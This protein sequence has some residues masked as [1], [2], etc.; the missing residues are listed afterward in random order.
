[1]TLGEK[2]KKVR[3]TFGLS[4]E[5]LGGMLNVSRQAITKWETDSGMPDITNLQQLSSL[6]ELT[7]DYFLNNDLNLPLLVIRKEL[8]KDKYENKLK[9]YDKILAE[10]FK[11]PWNVYTLIKSEKENKLETVFDILTGGVVY[12]SIKEL[13]DLSVYCLAIKDDVKLLV[14]IKNWVLTIKELP[15]NI[16]E[17]KFTIDNKSFRKG[18][19]IKL[20]NIN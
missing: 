11:S 2:I 8:D 12:G 4:Q 5:Q 3:N 15:S 16:N 17:K 20:D 18:G 13:S 1:M 7:I 10:Y 14:N 9:S 6:F 19:L